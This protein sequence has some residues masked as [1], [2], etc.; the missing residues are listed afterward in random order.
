MDKSY[1]ESK[2][3]PEDHVTKEI[4]ESKNAL[5]RKTENTKYDFRQSNDTKI[6]EDEKSEIRSTQSQDLRKNT[7]IVFEGKEIIE[8]IKINES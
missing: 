5:M 1:L 7:E 3:K 8:N 2:G 6:Q 4:D